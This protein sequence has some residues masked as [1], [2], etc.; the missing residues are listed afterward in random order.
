MRLKKKWG[1]KLFK[2]GFKHDKS[3]ER[4]DKYYEMLEKRESLKDSIPQ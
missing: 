4:D 2:N 1:N 3:L